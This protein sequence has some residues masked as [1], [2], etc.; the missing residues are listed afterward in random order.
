MIGLGSGN[1]LRM[2]AIQ[3]QV[4]HLGGTK[5]EIGNADWRLAV[6]KGRDG[7]RVPE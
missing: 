6:K 1:R 2:E 5:P 3:S 7:K 4:R